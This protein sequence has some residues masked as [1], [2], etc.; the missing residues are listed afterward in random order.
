MMRACITGAT[1]G[2]GKALTEA[3]AKRGYFLLLSGRSKQ[4]LD[5]MRSQ[6]KAHVEIVPCDL[7]KESERS[8]LI[9][10]IREF[11]P[12]LMIN[13]AGF[14]LYG[15]ALNHSVE[16]QIEIAEVNAL[17]PLQL[18]L[19]TARVLQAH[20][21]QGTILNIS[22]AAAFFVFPEFATYSAS[23]A[24]VNQFSLALDLELA[25]S[26]IRILTACPGQFQT[27]FRSR[28]SKGRDTRSPQNGMPVDAVVQAILHQ[29]ETGKPLQIIDWKYHLAVRIARLFP[30]RLLAPF[31]QKAIRARIE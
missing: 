26:G 12:T 24:F 29:I 4:T 31:L 18:T 3:L 30:Y 20:Q 9:E 28:A 8:I 25:P 22:S 21:A 27:G 2:L 6:L 17:V 11:K 1:H 5:E 7:A 13:N 14:G 19:E 16:E 15:P 23:K 10:A